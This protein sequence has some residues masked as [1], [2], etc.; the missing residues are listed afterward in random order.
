[1]ERSQ[2]QMNEV[3]VADKPVALLLVELL[4]Q[5][6]S[7]VLTL[8]EGTAHRAL[9]LQGGLVRFAEGSVLREL[10]GPAQVAAGLIKQASFDRAHALARQQNL[11]LHE[12]LASARVLT[13]DLLKTAL[14]QQ[15]LEVSL[16]ALS[17]SEGV[18]AFSPRPL[19]GPGAP[20]DMR[21]SPVALILEWAR[22]GPRPAQQMRAFLEERAQLRVSRSPELEKELFALKSL[23]PGESVTPAVGAGR[24]VGELLARIKE[25]ELPLL[26]ALSL[27]GLFVLGTSS[28]RLHPGAPA[29]AADEDRHK[30]FSP[31]E[32]ELRRMLFA[33]RDRAKDASHYQLLSVAPAAK[34]EEIRAGFIAAARKFHSDAFSGLEL[35]SARKVAE[36]LFQRVNEANQVLGNAKERGEYDVFLDRKA[37]G[38]PTDVGAIL[39]AES[40]FQKGELLFN[41]GKLEDA[42]ALFREAIALNHAEAEFHA[43]LGMTIFRRR[44]RPQD[45]QPHFDKARALDPRLA[46]VQVFS[47]QIQ[48]AQGD[49]EGARRTLRKLLEQ[50]PEN[51]MAKAEA[52]RLR[53]KAVQPQKKPGFLAGLFKKS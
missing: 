49:D 40:V 2:S 34:P 32:H 42:E 6:L 17:M 41:A 7:G 28:A 10:A 44:N 48:S 13:P 12:A 16:G 26:Y 45:A 53:A 29:T 21:T 3:R 11:A 51:A 19:D 37:K 33:E 14:K 22:R 38:L 15:T 39:K 25:P 20:P 31:K 8:R 47:A 46:S 9:Y 18:H 5:R 30:V 36:E 24:T 43:Y 4:R 52:A 50:E 1:V 27:T 23:W 35:G